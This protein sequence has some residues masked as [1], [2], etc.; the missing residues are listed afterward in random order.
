MITVNNHNA[1][2]VRGHDIRLLSTD[3]KPTEGISNGAV[4]LEIDTGRAY[5]FDAEG[6]RWCEVPAGSSISI[7]PATGVMF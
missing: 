6:G 3:V 1:Q 7:N 2:M 4:C 5:L